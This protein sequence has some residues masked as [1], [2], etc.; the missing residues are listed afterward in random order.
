MLISILE[1]PYF[2]T[3]GRKTCDDLGATTVSSLNECK[4]AINQ[5]MISQPGLTYNGTISNSDMPMGCTGCW[6]DIRCSPSEKHN[7]VWNTAGSSKYLKR[8]RVV[9]KS[10]GR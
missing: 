2:L 4:N 6:D 10:T 7:I 1:D 8:Y 9:C 3:L 5:L